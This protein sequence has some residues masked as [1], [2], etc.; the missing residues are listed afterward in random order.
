MSTAIFYDLENI[1]AFTAPKNYGEFKK[2]VEEIERSPLVDSIVMQKAYISTTHTAYIKYKN[3]LDSTGIEICGVN[4]KMNA[5]K[6]NLV[7][8][9]MNVDIT[10]DTISNNIDTV[11]IATGDGDFGF[12]CEALKKMGKK[13]VIASYGITTNKSIVML[14]DDWIDFSGKYELV[15]IDE[16]CRKRLAFTACDDYKAAVVKLAQMMKEDVL[17]SKYLRRTGIRTDEFTAL[18]SLMCKA[19]TFDNIRLPR[20][21]LLEVFLQPLGMGIAENKDGAYVVFSEK[22]PQS[23]E[24]DIYE[25]LSGMGKTF[26]KDR[27]RAW[28]EWFSAN[29]DSVKEL[30]YYLSFMTKNSFIEYNGDEVSIVPLHKCCAKLMEVTERRIRHYRLE[31]EKKEMDKLKMRFYKNASQLKK[32]PKKAEAEESTKPEQE[33]QEA[34]EEFVQAIKTS[35]GRVVVRATN[36]HVTRIEFTNEFIKYNHNAVTAKAVAELREYFKGERHEFT[37]PIAPEGTDFQKQVWAELLNIPYGETRSY[38]DIA[39]ALGKPKSVRAVGLACNKNPILVII[40]CHRVINANGD[41]SGYAGGVERKKALIEAESDREN[42]R[43]HGRLFQSGREYTDNPLL[44]QQTENKAE[45]VKEA[46]AEEVKEEVKAAVPEVTEEPKIEEV[47]EAVQLEIDEM[48]VQPE[49][50]E[51]P[52]AEEVKE[53]VQPEV[54]EEAKAEEVKEEVQPEV[55]EE[56]KA[57]EVQPEV[58]EEP[59]AEEVQ[60]EVQPEVTEEPKAEEI[61]EE[62]QPEAAEESKAEEVQEEV[63]P[64]VTEEPKAEEVQA[65][66]VKKKRGRKPGSKNK[67]TKAKTT[68]TTKTTKTAKTAKPSKTAAKSEKTDKA[69]KTEKAAAKD[70]PKTTRKPRTTKGTAKSKKVTEKSEKMTE[71]ADNTT[72]KPKRRPGRPRKVRPEAQSEAAQTAQSETKE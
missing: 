56:P 72:E 40:P 66:P 34:A 41:L 63:Q 67:T 39:A 10:A 46:V 45:A 68:K 11:V 24:Y 54:T 4:P 14:C 33:Q 60:A 37:V 28:H 65:E 25:R 5:N 36:E 8:F 6:A 62:V 59:K 42:F 51:E 35:F 44:Q 49:V 27:F 58:T 47:H 32:A 29:A 43:R 22:E 1:S 55:T 19:P 9:K 50:T 38:K 61:K 48:Q 12:L 26:S 30:T 52:K 23:S 70:K 20:E 2:S 7:D 57:E 3:F 31:P 69:E 17:I 15:S 71:N 13:V 21:E 18:S 16:L 53:E 64:E